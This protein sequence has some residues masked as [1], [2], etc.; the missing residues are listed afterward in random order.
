[1]SISCS[2]GN[3]PQPWKPEDS[4]LVIYAMTLDLQDAGRYERA[5]TTLRDTYGKSVMS[6]F[7]PLLTP[8]DA[9]LDGSNGTDSPPCPRPGSSTLRQLALKTPALRRAAFNSGGGGGGPPHVQF[10]FT[11]SNAI[12]VIRAIHRERRRVSSRY[13]M[14]LAIRVLNTWYHRASSSSGPSSA[15]ATAGKASLIPRCLKPLAFPPPERSAGHRRD[16]SQGCACHCR[17]QQR[18]ASPGGFTNAYADT[19]DLVSIDIAM[20][21]ETLYQT[22][23]GLAKIDTRQETIFV[24]GSA[25]V[26]LDV[27]W[28]EWGPIIGQDSHRRLLALRW[29]AH[30]PAAANFSLMQLETARTAAEALAIAHRAGIP[31]QNFVVADADGAIGWTI[32]GR[33]PKRVGFDGRLPVSWT[34]RRPRW[35]GLLA[36]DDVPQLLAPASGRLWSA[37]QRMIG[38]DAFAK[39]GD[40]GYEQPYRAAQIRDDLAALEHAAPRD[41]LAIQLDDRALFLARWQELLLATLTPKAVAG[42]SSRADLLRLARHW[43]GR[44]STDSVSYRLVRAFRLHVAQLVFAPIFAPCVEADPDFDYTRFNYETPLWTLLTQK[45]L[46]LLDPK[47]VP[48]GRPAAGRGR[49]SMADLHRGEGVAPDRR[50]RAAINTAAH[51]APVQPFPA[52]PARAF[53]RHAGGSAGRRRKYAAGADVPVWRE[54]TLRRSQPRPRRR[55]H[56]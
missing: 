14:H 44:A 28:T 1:M 29:T 45:P 42:N 11:G 18:A 27:Q 10:V 3:D 12:G 33:L 19:S 46:H 24:K 43:E 55:R 53:S 37:N 25:P 49:C 6:F 30:E 34:F 20:G 47:L 51:P 52:R 39:I 26:T 4:V 38:G 17:R 2:G 8:D 32:A 40:G 31:A 7:A 48:L 21:T 5:L 56:L 41:L 9:A 35:D 50:H 16:A 13:D 15:E 23:H 36:P 22:R 54:R